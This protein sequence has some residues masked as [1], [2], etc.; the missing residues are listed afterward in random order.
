MS[1]ST[2]P[3]GTAADRPSRTADTLADMSGGTSAGSGAQ[4]RWRLLVVDDEPNVQAALRRLLRGEGYELLTANSAEDALRLL[5]QQ[6]VH[7]V[8]SDERMP[9]RTGTAFLREVRR[10]WP[11][12]IRIILSGYSAVKTILAAVN[13]GA[14]YKFFTK[15][16]N[17]EELK[18]SIRRAFEQHALEAEN[19]R[20]ARQLAEQNARLLELNAQ[21]T[22]RADDAATGLDFVQELL[23]AVS[24]GVVTID[25]TG[26]VVGANQ[27]AHELIGAD[28]A[29]L[30]GLPAEQALPAGLWA[31]LRPTLADRQPVAAGELHFGQR[32]LQWR[33]RAV[34]TACGGPRARGAVVTIWEVSV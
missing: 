4:P 19:R 25:E 2:S 16:W 30:L 17:D 23:D 18:I 1:A 12:T 10:R 9:G 34:E 3:A 6:S 29:G 8:I 26:L 14:V 28:F 20:M 21:L 13:E 24:A 31:A 11:E 5:E 22:Q 27:R 15:P 32:R 33:A 7:L